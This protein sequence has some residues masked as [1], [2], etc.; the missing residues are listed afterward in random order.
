MNRCTVQTQINHWNLEIGQV[1][2]PGVK[3]YALS[4]ILFRT[5]S[6]DLRAGNIS[7][8]ESQ[9]KSYIYQD[10][11]EKPIQLVLYQMVEQGG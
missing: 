8:M 7:M 5:H 6:V 3:S 11:F 10:M 4:R 9:C 2:A 1:Y